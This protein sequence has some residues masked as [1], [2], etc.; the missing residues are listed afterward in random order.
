MTTMLTSLILAAALT[1]QAPPAKKPQP[2]PPMTA[3]QRRRSKYQAFHARQAAED[4]ALRA[5]QEKVQREAKEEYERLL[6]YM[7]E[8]QRQ[9]LER[10]SAADRNEAL[11]RMARAAEATARATEAQAYGYGRGTGYRSTYGR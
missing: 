11:H 6:P 10:Q 1:G 3:A 8:H 5:A 7:L 2:A 4:R 9:M